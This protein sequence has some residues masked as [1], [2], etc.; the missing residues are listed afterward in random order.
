MTSIW[1]G[2]TALLAS[3][4]AGTALLGAPAQNAPAPQ[5]LPNVQP[6]SITSEDVPY[7]FPVAY[8]PLTMYGQSVRMAYMD[9]APLGPSNGRTV[10]LL[11]GMNFAGY[12]WGGPIDVLRR[13][14]FRVV[15]P[16]QIGFGRS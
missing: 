11:H 5:N 14:G 13:G 16:D 9:V 4:L 15:V 1:R 7:P 8:L 10:V 2:L 3:A 6:G 12:Y